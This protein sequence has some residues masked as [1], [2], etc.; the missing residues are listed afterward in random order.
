METS[1]RRTPDGRSDAV[2]WYACHTRAR[3]EKRVA[4]RLAERDVEAY[5]PSASLLREWAD[6]RKV[7]EFPL[8]PGYVFARFELSGLYRVLSIPGVATVV[9]LAGRPVP[10]ADA[11]IENIR[12]VA[13]GL[14]VTNERPEP[15][16]LHPGDPVR[17][18]DGPFR[19]VVGVV[20][21]VRGHRRVLVGLHAIGQGITIVVDLHAIEACP[22]RESR[23]MPTSPPPLPAR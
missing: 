16:P 2:R 1:A 7:V 14:A 23:I 6:R 9:R 20:S 17:V 13:A 21:E 5:L 22:R 18:V 8:F 11:E 15:Q 19:G 10:V 4:L 12:R 3:S